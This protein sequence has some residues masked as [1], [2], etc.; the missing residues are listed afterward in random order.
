MLLL[1]AL[2]RPWCRRSDE[3]RAERVRRSTDRAQINDV[4]VRYAEG[5]DRRDLDAVRSCF[6]PDVRAEYGGVVLDPGVDALIEHVSIVSTFV[7]SMH[8]LGNVHRRGRRRRGAQ[9]LP[10]RRLRAAG[11]DRRRAPVHAR[12]DVRGPLARLADGF[13][14][15]ERR[16]VPEWSVE[17]PVEV[18]TASFDVV[19]ENLALI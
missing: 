18:F 4:L 6:A 2:R 10:V 14:I 1:R 17:A 8:L 11:H 15:T 3:R 13:R 9:H 16:H 7:G 12:A 5:L 19:P